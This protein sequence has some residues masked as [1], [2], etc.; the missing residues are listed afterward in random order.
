[1]ATEAQVQLVG[2]LNR[3]P[4]RLDAMIKDPLRFREAMSA[5]HAIVGSDYRYVPKDRTAYAAF[6]RMRRQT[7][8]GSVWQAHQAYFSF[9]L[10]NDPGAALILDPVVTVHPDQVFFEVFSKD[11]GTYAK[12]GVD[13]GGRSRGPVTFGTTNIDFSQSLY[14]GIQQMRSYRRTRLRSAR[15][16]QL[17]TPGP[18]PRARCWRSGSTCRLLAAGF[19][20]C[21][22]PPLPTDT[23]AVAAVDSSLLR[24][25]RC[26]PTTRASGAAC[27]SS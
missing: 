2:N 26:T 19:Y 25:L 13:R 17:A 22:R 1:T 27:G 21:S 23:L 5:L 14:D 7:A 11:E 3:S 18:G 16:D 24:H 4:V 9:L 6:V 10:R 12:L 15:C 20:K 8:S